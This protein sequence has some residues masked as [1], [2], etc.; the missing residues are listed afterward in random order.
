MRSSHRL[1]TQLVQLVALALGSVRQSAA[2]TENLL[3]RAASDDIDRRLGDPALSPERVAQRL[4]IS[5]R[6][7]HKLFA[8]HG[9]SFGRWLSARRVQRAH[10]LLL[11]PDRSDWT[12]TR[13]AH[14]C[15]FNDPAYFSRVFK[16]AYGLTPSQLRR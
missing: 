9:P 16:N 6:Y 15:G 2:I 3:L 12:V 11:D 10:S 1:G 4:G 8:G 7:L 13:I 5:V 14:E